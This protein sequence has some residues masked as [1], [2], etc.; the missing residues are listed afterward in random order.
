MDTIKYVNIQNSAQE[1]HDDSETTE[2]V[3]RNSNIILCVMWKCNKMVASYY[4][5][6]QKMV[7]T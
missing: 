4:N 6:D 7:S 5:V 2:E 1:E 3:D